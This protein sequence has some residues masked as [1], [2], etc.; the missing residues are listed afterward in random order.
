MYVT[1]YSGIIFVEGKHPEATPIKPIEV[2]IKGIEHSQ[3]KSLD[4]VKARMVT[5]ARSTGANAI[6]EFK[7][8]QKSPSFLGSLFNLDDVGWYGSGIAAKL[9]EFTYKQIIEST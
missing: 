9:P 3:L 8:G 1:S 7:Y 5:I 2:S 4:D 6:V